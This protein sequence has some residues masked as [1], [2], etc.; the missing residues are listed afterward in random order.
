MSSQPND[1]GRILKAEREKRAIPLETVHET[2]KI[3]LDSLRAIEEGYRIRTLSPFYYKSFVRSYAKYLGMDA[4]EISGMIPSSRPAPVAPSV[5][6]GKV[7]AAPKTVPSFR[8]L[9]VLNL[10]ARS[11]NTKKIRKFVQIGLIVVVCLGVLALIVG[12]VRKFSQRKAAAPTTVEQPKKMASRDSKPK[13]EPV[14]KAEPPKAD[15]PKSVR[16]ATA[17]VS[18]QPAKAVTLTVRAKTT[19]WLNVRADGMPV[20]Q[21]SLTRNNHVT[22]EANK[23]I[24]LS[25]RDIEQLDYEVNGKPIGKISRSGA[26][27]RKV[28]ITPDG[29]SVE[30]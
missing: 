17:P 9:P 8:P 26:R 5:V 25:G 7:A 10:F 29:L 27:I 18:S 23:R 24:E 4:D 28:I 3:P 15:A 30:R 1:I 19:V 13:A 16:V 12:A 11:G 6:A 2:T 14:R 20:F 22:W 21:G